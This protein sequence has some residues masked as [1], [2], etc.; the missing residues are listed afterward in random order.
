M[1]VSPDH[2]TSQWKWGRRSSSQKVHRA[3]CADRVHARPAQPAY[4]PDQK[5]RFM[6]TAVLILTP[7]G[8]DLARL[9]R[10]ALPDETRIFGPSC[11]VG[12]CYGT[13]GARPTFP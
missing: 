13:A 1:S 5:P 9:L 2:P 8:L 4:P 3:C 10:D 6:K 7:S 12:R 11:V